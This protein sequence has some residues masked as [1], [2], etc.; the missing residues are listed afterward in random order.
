VS[1]GEV[2]AEEQAKTDVPVA[3]LRAP[4]RLLAPRQNHEI[5]LD[6]LRNFGSRLEELL[7]LARN[8]G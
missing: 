6:K 5:G 1:I 3:R 8:R 2:D 4:A 7:N